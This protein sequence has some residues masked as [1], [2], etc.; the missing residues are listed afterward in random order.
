MN[1]LHGAY[2]VRWKVWPVYFLTPC[3]D[4]FCRNSKISIIETS[5]HFKI[6]PAH[7]DLRHCTSCNQTNKLMNIINEYCYVRLTDWK[8]YIKCIS[9]LSDFQYKYIY[10]S[11]M[12]WCK[13]WHMA[14]LQSSLY[15]TSS[16]LNGYHRCMCLYLRLWVWNLSK[17]TLYVLF[18]LEKKGVYHWC[19]TV[20]SFLLAVELMHYSEEC[21]H[22]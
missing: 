6:N 21:Q 14:A 8:H 2:Q 17:S 18:Q 3:K 11:L 20:T 4:Q 12:H 19:I 10:I 5:L 15:T 16:N 13:I 1:V 7:C 9:V 22:F